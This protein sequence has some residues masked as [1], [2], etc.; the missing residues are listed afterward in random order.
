M[1]QTFEATPDPESLIATKLNI[2]IN[3]DPTN[4]TE[5]NVAGFSD[6]LDG[7]IRDRGSSALWFYPASV[8]FF[9]V[10]FLI[11]DDWPNQGAT[12]LALGLIPFTI[13]L[14]RGDTGDR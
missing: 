10:H 14:P 8:S 7:I 2:F 13:G 11:A 12:I 9:I 4:T 3:A 1:L 5:L 6:L